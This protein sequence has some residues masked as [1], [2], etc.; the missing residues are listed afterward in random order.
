MQEQPLVSIIIPTFNRAHLIGETLDSVLAQT[1]DN[2][3]CIVVDDGSTD[4]TDEV[5]AEYMARDSRF[6]YHH[7]PED[8]LPGGNAARNYGFEVSK[9]EYIQWFDSD[10]LMDVDY[11]MFK[12]ENIKG[13]DLLIT[14]GRKKHQNNSYVDLRMSFV[15][16]HSLYKEIVRYK[17]E[18][19]TPTVF[20]R[21]AVLVGKKLFDEKLRR[22]QETEFFARLTYENE[23]K[24]SFINQKLFTYILHKDSKSSQPQS[25]FLNCK[26]KYNLDNLD[27]G[28]IIKDDLLIKKFYKQSMAILFEYIRV[29]DKK[30]F[31]VYYKKFVRIVK[32]HKINVTALNFLWLLSYTGVHSEK[33]RKFFINQI[34]NDFNNYPNV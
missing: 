11:L 26:V 12:I 24:Y 32:K 8:R 15:E 17:S 13:S 5:M 10:D 3:E 19:M 23:L 16:N 9:G 7:R 27:R 21:R 4:N 1:Y 34:D 6:Q 30:S 31:K 2:W 20:M 22:G 25:V 18:V 14:S 28:L 33:I 29:K